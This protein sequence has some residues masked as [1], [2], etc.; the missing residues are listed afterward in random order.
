MPN[1]FQV[2][3]PFFEDH[4]TLPD[5]IESLVLVGVEPASIS[6]VLSGPR[7]NI[8]EIRDRYKIELICSDGP[9]TPSQAR[10]LGGKRATADYIAFLDADTVVTESW[11]DALNEVASQSAVLLT[12]DTCHISRDPSWIEKSWFSQIEKLKSSY[13]NGANIIVKRSFFLELNGFD[14]DLETGEDYDFSIRASKLG[15][16]PKLDDRFFVYH[17]GYPKTAKEFYRREKWHATGDLGSFSAFF[18]S[19]VMWAS[20]LYI[21]C[22]FV[23]IAAALTFQPEYFLIAILIMFFISISLTLYKFGWNKAVLTNSVIMNIYLGGRG[24]AL[25]KKLLKPSTFFRKPS[26]NPK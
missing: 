5:L 9:L 10:N 1:R 24:M 25:A 12:G 22:L 16:E 17:E 14:E 4:D 3:V 26:L 18:K 19:K 21:F 13:I 20:T 2:I 8:F 11:A 6:V 7:R 23:L 15:V